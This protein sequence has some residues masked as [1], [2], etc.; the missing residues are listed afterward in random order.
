[1]HLLFYKSE[2]ESLSFSMFYYYAGGLILY[3]TWFK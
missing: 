3:Q 1:M 2:V